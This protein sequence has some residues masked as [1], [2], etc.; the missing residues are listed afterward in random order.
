MFVSL[1]IVMSL[2]SVVVVLV[3]TVAGLWLTLGLL[4]EAPVGRAALSLFAALALWSGAV[5]FARAAGARVPE[6]EPARVDLKAGSEHGYLIGR[7]GDQVFLGP[8]H[9]RTGQ[10]TTRARAQRRRCDTRRRRR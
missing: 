4:A 6:L 7:S 2:G 5:G 8:E 1:W 3:V 10:D 9:G